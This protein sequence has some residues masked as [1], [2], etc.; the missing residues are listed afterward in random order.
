MEKRL[1]RQ[2]VALA[3]FGL[4]QIGF[5]VALTQ[6]EVGVVYMSTGV[7]QLLVLVLSRSVL[8]EH[9]TRDHLIA[10]ALIMGGLI[11]YAG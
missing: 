6:L 2:V 3:L 1:S 9:V 8:R 5:F 10:V 7:I 4:A 11:V